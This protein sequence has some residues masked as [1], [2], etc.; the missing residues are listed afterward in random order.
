MEIKSYD[1]YKEGRIKVIFDIHNGEVVGVSVGNN[2]VSTKANLSFYVADYVAY[3]I[4][5]CKLNLDGLNITLSVR[6]GET[7]FV[8]EENEEYLKAKEIE[9]LEEKLRELK[10][11]E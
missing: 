7:F 4:D 2:A 3:Q 1:E 6:D 8:P 10:N 11:T 9:E 5:K